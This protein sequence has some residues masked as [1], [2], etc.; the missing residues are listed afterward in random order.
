M[1]IFGEIGKVGTAVVETL[2][3]SGKSKETPSWG[4]IPTKFTIPGID[5]DMGKIVLDGIAEQS[6][7][8]YIDTYIGDQKTNVKSALIN[9]LRFFDSLSQLLKFAVYQIL[10]Y[11]LNT[12]DI[13]RLSINHGI[14]PSILFY[15]TQ[16]RKKD[17]LFVIIPFIFLLPCILFVYRS[18]SLITLVIPSF[19]SLFVTLFKAIVSV[20]TNA[21]T[22][23]TYFALFFI[24]WLLE[25]LFLMSSLFISVPP[26]AAT[27]RK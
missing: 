24:I 10:C 13:L 27:P 23:E 6:A 7:V 26:S 14:I 22:G 19:V 18:L 16:V 3:G 1:S 21:F 12:L 17:V 15:F 11:F 20:F 5:L 8:T 2:A 25:Q 9:F 4:V